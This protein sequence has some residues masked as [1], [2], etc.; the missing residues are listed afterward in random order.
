[1]LNDKIE[2]QLKILTT[3]LNEYSFYKHDIIEEFLNT[4]KLDGTDRKSVV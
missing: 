1:M 3:P 2:L 4:T